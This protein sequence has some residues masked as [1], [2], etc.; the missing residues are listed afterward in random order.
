MMN[1]ILLL[2]RMEQTLSLAWLPSEESHEGGGVVLSQRR[3][4]GGGRRAQARF[5][6]CPA[7]QQTTPFLIGCIAVR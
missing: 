5:R 2:R 4:A 1:R 3:R 7:P 6:S